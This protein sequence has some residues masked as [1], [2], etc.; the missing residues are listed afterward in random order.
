[1]ARYQILN[2]ESQ[3]MECQH[4]PHPVHEVLG[5]ESICE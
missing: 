4:F 3:L 1:M 2:L 5:G